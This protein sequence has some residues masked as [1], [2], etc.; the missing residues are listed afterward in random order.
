MISR[1]KWYFVRLPCTVEEALDRLDAFEYHAGQEAGFVVDRT[2]DSFEYYWQTP[3]YLTSIDEDG[4][5]V[6]SEV[7]S[8]SHQKVELIKGRRLIFRMQ[9]PPRSSKE[10]FNM[11]EK[12]LGFGFGATVLAVDDATI[13]QAIK[14]FNSVALNSIK[15]SGAISEASALARVEIASK[16]GLEMSLLDRFALNG[17]IVESA[18]YSVIAK[19]ISG[20]VGFTRSGICKISGDLAPLILSKVELCLLSHS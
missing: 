8:L 13:K 14:G 4:E 1:F 16:R 10:L 2:S 11:L 5:T 3:M 6:R 12:I 15:F 7:F 9:D 17:R 19:G 20:Q 18:S